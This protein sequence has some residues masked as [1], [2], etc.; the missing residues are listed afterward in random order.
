MRIYGSTTVWNAF[1]DLFDYLSTAAVI[2]NVIFCVHGGLSPSIQRIDQIK[3]LNRFQEV[4]HDG[5]LAD[6]M[7]SDPDPDGEGFT[8]SQ[9]YFS[10]SSF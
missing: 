6:L 8:P 4:P 10:F 9:R 5:A 7:W 3:V 2:D 1:V